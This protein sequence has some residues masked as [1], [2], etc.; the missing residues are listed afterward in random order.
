[1]LLHAVAFFETSA[2]KEVRILQYLDNSSAVLLPK[3]QDKAIVYLYF[4]N[5]HNLFYDNVFPTL[6]FF[7]YSTLFLK[8]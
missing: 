7:D 6:S 1:M 3:F 4:I 8:K 2:L 5:F